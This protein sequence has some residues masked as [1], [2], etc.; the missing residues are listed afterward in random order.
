VTVRQKGLIK[1]VLGS[2]IF[3]AILGWVYRSGAQQTHHVYE[4]TLMALP[5]AFA[6]VGLIECVTGT[7][8]SKYSDAWERL[9]GWQR[10]V[11]GT[12]FLLVVSAIL[13]SMLYLTIK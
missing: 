13:F 9:K 11:L 2:A 10:G 3:G 8:F 1:F 6:V 5:G 4:P 7:P 12:S